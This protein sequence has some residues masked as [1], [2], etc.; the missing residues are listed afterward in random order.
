MSWSGTFLTLVL[1]TLAVFLSTANIA[2]AQS[3]T[4]PKNANNYYYSGN[5]YY[6]APSASPTGGQKQSQPINEALPAQAPSV[7]PEISLATETGHATN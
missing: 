7:A 1:M 5:W 4:S 2:K 3:A 6:A